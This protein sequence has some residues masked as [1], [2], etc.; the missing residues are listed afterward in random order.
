LEQ[1]CT[2]LIKPFPNILTLDFILHFLGKKSTIQP[3]LKKYSKK[4]LTPHRGKPP[5]PFY[6]I[7]TRINGQWLRR[8]GQLASPTIGISNWSTTAIGNWPRQQ[9]L[10]ISRDMWA[11]GNTKRAK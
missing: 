1:I 8:N 11:K 10:A 9:S 5:L 3:S 7:K 6:M 4:I 2:P